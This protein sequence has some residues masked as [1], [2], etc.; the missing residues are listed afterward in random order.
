MEP[1]GSGKSVLD[2]TILVFMSGMQGSN[3][4]ADKLPIVLG[5]S[6]G[7]VFKTDYHNAFPSEVRLADVH[8]TVLQS[9]FGLSNVAKLGNSSGIVPGLLV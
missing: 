9:G 1:D 7:G 5:G 3:H 6:G 2:N 4:Q 8:L